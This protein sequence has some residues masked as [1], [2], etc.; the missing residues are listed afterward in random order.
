MH[1]A[2]LYPEAVARLVVLNSPLYRDGSQARDTIL[3]TGPLF[4]FLLTSPLRSAG[5][6]TIRSL[7][8]PIWGRHPARAREGAIRNVV[9]RGQGIDDLRHLEVETL[10]ITGL[11]DRVEYLD[12]LQ[13]T[14][15]PDNVD[16]LVAPTGHHL[17]ARAPDLV[18]WAIARMTSA[19]PLAQSE[20]RQ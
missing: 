6:V 3:G 4:R 20:I 16:V 1:L 14:E 12:N 13:A 8:F 10:V 5:W 15:L 9:F 18:E 11:R 17:P 19:L 2:R 7:A